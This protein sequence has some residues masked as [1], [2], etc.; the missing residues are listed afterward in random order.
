MWATFSHSNK[1]TMKSVEKY[2]LSVFNNFGLSCYRFQNDQLSISENVVK[3]NYFLLFFILAVKIISQAC[4][5]L[6]IFLSEGASLKHFTSF[7]IAMISLLAL[8][9]VLT[10]CYII[11][12][13][14]KK[15][16]EIL[17]LTKSIARFNTKFTNFCVK[18]CFTKSKTLFLIFAYLIILRLVEN[19][20]SMNSNIWVILTYLYKFL[21]EAVI[22]LFIFVFTIF[23]EYVTSLLKTLNEKIEEATTARN[24]KDLN[25]CFV[26][27]EDIFNLI[28]SFYKI[29]GCQIFFLTLFMTI[30]LILQ[31]ITQLVLKFTNFSAFEHFLIFRL[32]R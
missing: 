18:F 15:R 31:V 23:I 2:F 4:L 13:H 12:N 3:K 7:S 26:F 24:F 20:L 27:Y 1:S 11:F 25:V 21:C 5:D 19:I 8:A 9:P 28:A 14:Q 6:Q 10:S 16:R 32:L 29:F 22:V 30:K 17:V